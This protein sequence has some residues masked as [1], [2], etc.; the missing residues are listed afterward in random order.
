MNQLAKRFLSVLMALVLCLGLLP[1]IALAEGAYTVSFSENGTV[2]FTETADAGQQ[3]TLPMTTD[4]VIDDYTF[5]G[6]V[7]EVLSETTNK[8]AQV[9]EAGQA[10]TVTED[11]SYYALYSRTESQEGSGD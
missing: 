11:I 5:V 3:I 4:E 1:G 7:T 9:F 6:W 2:T 10:V 8:P